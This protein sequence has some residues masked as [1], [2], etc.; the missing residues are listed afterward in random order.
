[1]AITKITKLPDNVVNSD[2]ILDNTIV[3]ADVSPSAAIT[4]AKLQV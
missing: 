3:N 4:N 1:M 2:K